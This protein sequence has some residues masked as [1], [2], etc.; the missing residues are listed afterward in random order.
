MF[1]ERITNPGLAH[2]S[3]Y[4]ADGGEALV[5]D[6]RRDV[7]VYRELAL[8]RGERLGNRAGLAASILARHGFERVSNLLGGHRALQSIR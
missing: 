7:D 6:P 1:V 5:C 3:Y 4:I 8:A 2:N